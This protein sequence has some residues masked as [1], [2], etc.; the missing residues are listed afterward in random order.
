MKI[1]RRKLPKNW[2]LLLHIEEKKERNKNIEYKLKFI[3]DIEGYPS[4]IG[5]LIVAKKGK[6][7]MVLL[8]SV[9]VDMRGKGCGKML[10]EHAIKKLGSLTTEYH[11]ASS[12]AQVLWKRLI[13]LYSY[14]IDFFNGEITV[15]KK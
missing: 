5:Y 3:K 1:K 2:K 13:Q 6:K 7:H 9:E 12:M 8:S 15:Y 11:K 4:T 14:K 10:Y